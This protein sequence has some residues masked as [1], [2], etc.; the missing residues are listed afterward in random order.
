VP[1]LAFEDPVEPRPQARELDEGVIGHAFMT[2][3]P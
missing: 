3:W 2:A 1:A